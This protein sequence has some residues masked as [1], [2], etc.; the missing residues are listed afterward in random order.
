[1]K[2]QCK[3][4][5]IGKYTDFQK[6]TSVVNSY[7]K[8]PTEVPKKVFDGDVYSIDWYCLRPYICKGE[9]GTI[10]SRFFECQECTRYKNYLDCVELC[11]YK[12]IVTNDQTN[13]TIRSQ[14]ENKAIVSDL[15][16][17]QVL[18][19]HYLRHHKVK[20]IN[21]PTNT[22]VCGNKGF[23]YYDIQDRPNSILKIVQSLSKY[24]FS[25]NSLP[26][27][28]RGFV[29]PNYSSLTTKDGIRIRNDKFND[30]VLADWVVKAEN[31]VFELNLVSERHLNKFKY[32]RDTGELNKKINDTLNY[33][34]LS[35]DYKDYD[36]FLLSLSGK[37]NEYES[38]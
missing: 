2:L 34:I 21:Y 24:N 13:L 11:D 33:M 26:E 37:K 12:T 15:F 17:T 36:S 10:R 18:I 22:F 25:F 9:S 5:Q 16:T 19:N 28:D 29:V 3:A 4:K 1:M 27:L 7:L 30:F 35:D 20:N 38:I 32:L 14:Y 31:D 23:L 8:E 6:R